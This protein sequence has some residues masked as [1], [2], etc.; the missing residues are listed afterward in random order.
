MGFQEFFPE[1]CSVDFA[2]FD[3]ARCSGATSPATTTSI[4]W[5]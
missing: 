4:D 1:N 3:I 2:P 5:V